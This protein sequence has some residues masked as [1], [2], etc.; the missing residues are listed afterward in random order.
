MLPIQADAVILWMHVLAA[1]VWIGGQVVIAAIIP[2][3]RGFDWLATSTGRRY[4]V[5]AWPA[6]VVLVV[7]GILN[8]RSAGISAHDLVETAVGRTLTIKLGFGVVIAQA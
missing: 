8:M 2:L 5:V 3:V 4:Q 7:T 6:Y 1:C